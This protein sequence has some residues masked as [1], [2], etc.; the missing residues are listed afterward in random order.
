[1]GSPDPQQCGYLFHN[2][3]F[4]LQADQAFLENTMVRGFTESP[5]YRSRFGPN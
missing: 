4:R 5:E 3:R 2:A 1:V